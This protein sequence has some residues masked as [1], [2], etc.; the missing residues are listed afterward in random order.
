MT[1]DARTGSRD[2]TRIGALWAGVLLGPVMSLVALE[3]GYVLADRACATGRMLPVH[4]TFV[5]SLLV[6]LAGGALAWREW[7]V[8]GTTPARDEG[9]PAGRSR[10]L[11][12]LGLLAA[13]L[14]A[15]TILALWSAA[16]FYHPCQ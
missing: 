1:I 13:P 9:G 14:F 16:F 12:L 7:R 15:L 10:F 3:V 5:A 2:G 8:W 4:L 11:A 6:S